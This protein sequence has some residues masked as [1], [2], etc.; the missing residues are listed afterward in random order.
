MRTKKGIPMRKTSHVPLLA[1]ILVPACAHSPVYQSSG[2]SIRDGVKIAIVGQ[3]CNQYHE[4][5]FEFD[6]FVGLEL[7]L[8]VRNATDAPLTV[9][10]D[11]IRVVASDGMSPKTLTWEAVK[12]I[13]I[14]AGGIQRISVRYMDR[15]SLE[16][17]GPLDLDLNNAVTHGGAPLALAPIHFVARN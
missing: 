1:L 4:P 15:G 7:D 16:C 11:M 14:E 17:R 9:H 10:R 6:D 2:P 5:N 13:Q 8:E 12:P 3:S